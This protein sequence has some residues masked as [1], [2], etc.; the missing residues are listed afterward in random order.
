MNKLYATKLENLEE[1]DE[2]FEPYSLSGMNWEE[3]ENQS[4]PITSKEIETIINCLPPNK[5]Q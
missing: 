2:Y 4:R 3:I 5:I 1:M